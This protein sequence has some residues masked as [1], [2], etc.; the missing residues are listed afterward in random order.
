M[1]SSEETDVELR[2]NRRRSAGWNAVSRAEVVQSIG[3]R[4]RVRFSKG[5]N[6]YSG[7]LCA[8]IVTNHS[9]LCGDG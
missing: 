6:V 9:R 4:G 8:R 1:Y 3:E 2:V 5:G 7:V